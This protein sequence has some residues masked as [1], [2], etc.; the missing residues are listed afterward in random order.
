MSDCGATRRE[1]QRSANEKRS[2]LFAYAINVSET[3]QCCSNLLMGLLID[4]PKLNDYPALV[5]QLG[6]AR[7]LK[8]V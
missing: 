4:V 1:S 3:M 2:L 8:R 6:L 5:S 7:A